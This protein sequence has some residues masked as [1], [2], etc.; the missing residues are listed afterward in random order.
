MVDSFTQDYE[1]WLERAL[2]G[3]PRALQHVKIEGTNS[4]ASPLYIFAR[5]FHC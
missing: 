3:F 2:V 1:G 5:N 4:R